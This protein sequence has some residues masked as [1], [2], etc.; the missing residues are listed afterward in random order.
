MLILRDVF[1]RNYE[2]KAQYFDYLKYFLK[3]M[4]RGPKHCKTDEVRQ[5]KLPISPEQNQ[6]FLKQLCILKGKLKKQNLR[7]NSSFNCQLRAWRL[8]MASLTL[9]RL[10]TVIYFERSAS[11]LELT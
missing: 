8:L 2:V 7:R 5:K 9:Q 11:R 4:Y 1:E 10:L 6:F 3:N